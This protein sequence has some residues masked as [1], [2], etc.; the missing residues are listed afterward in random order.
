MTAN[1]TFGR[2]Y[3]P[4]PRDR[5]HAMTPLLGVSWV[6]HRTWSARGLPM[7]QGETP[8]CV[9]YS[10]RGLLL[11]S[12]VINKPAHPTADEIYASAQ[13]LD[14]LRE[15]SPADGT[16]IRGG[17]KCLKALGFLDEYVWARSAGEVVQFVLSR[18]PVV[19]GLN[20]Y[21]SMMETD[22]DG[23]LRIANGARFVG[24]HAIL[25]I[26]AN[27]DRDAVRLVNSWGVNWGDHG[28]AWLSVTDLAR[29]LDEDGEAGAPTELKVLT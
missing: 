9:G 7:D 25:A 26:G 11:A 1:R 23:W 2:I 19:L 6:R 24:G 3:D 10:C 14:G 12:P 13:L 4:D 18:G 15:T 8:H 17:F 22:R 29:L 28:R 20:W 21:D 27:L 5:A 16:T